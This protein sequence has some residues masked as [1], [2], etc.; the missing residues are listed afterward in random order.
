MTPIVGGLIQAAI[1]V[2]DKVIPDPQAKAQAKLELLKLEQ[3][4]EFK[5]LD[6][7]LQVML[8]QAAINQ[9]EA[10]SPDAFRGSWRP[11]VGWV[12][13][14]GMAWTYVASPLLGWLSTAQGWPVPPTIDTFDLLIMLGGMLG[15][16]GMRSFER[17][18]GRA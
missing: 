3:E 18:K 14:T 4:G 10:K 8:A 16:G 17:I 5:K 13:V 15:F 12:C 11:A 1:S 2:I 7:D 9:E 6:A